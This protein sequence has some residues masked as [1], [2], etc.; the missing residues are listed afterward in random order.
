[1][2]IEE[3]EWS[4]RG[5]NP[6]LAF[7]RIKGL[8]TLDEKGVHV[9][10]AV[11]RYR[12]NCARELDR[13]A[14]KVIPEDKLLELSA[15]RP[16]TREAVFDVLRPGSPLARRHGDG[17]FEAVLQGLADTEP[18]PAPKRA[19]TRPSA[20]APGGGDRLL[21]P[22]K[23]WRNEMVNRKGYAP[24]VVA[25][26]TLLKEIARM[27]PQSLDE[28]ALVPGVRSWQIADFGEDIVALV[29]S[30]IDDLPPPRA[31]KRRRRRRA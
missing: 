30:V 23:N 21:L 19:A 8:N 4:G 11:A 9:L 13:P 2:L 5:A 27:A 1:M 10:R 28:L 12:D 6:D 20:T 22:L 26:N 18:L 29:R 3:R 25:S 24:T 14:F 16:T 17:L 15:R 7:Q 31:S